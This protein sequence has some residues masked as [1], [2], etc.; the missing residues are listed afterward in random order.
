MTPRPYEAGLWSSEKRG[1]VGRVKGLMKC[2][3][4]GENVSEQ[5][6]C[7]LEVFGYIKATKKQAFGG[8]GAWFMLFIGF[9]FS[10]DFW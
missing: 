6:G 5:F 3:G 2:M 7:F 10:G 4:F 8:A 1:L 9:C